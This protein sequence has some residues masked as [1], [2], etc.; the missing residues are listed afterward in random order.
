M[1]ESERISRAVGPYGRPTSFGQKT[2]GH[3]G[4]MPVFFSNGKNARPSEGYKNVLTN[5][6]FRPPG[7]HNDDPPG[8]TGEAIPLHSTDAYR[9]GWDRIWGKK[10][11]VHADS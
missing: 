7:G 8:R 5:Q 3:K 4:W 9:E 11:K 6:E 1:A 10:E 2:S